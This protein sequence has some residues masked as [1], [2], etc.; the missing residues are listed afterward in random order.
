L[1]PL[2]FSPN[3]IFYNKCKKTNC[4]VETQIEEA[5]QEEDDVNQQNR[6]IQSAHISE[7]AFA[8]AAGSSIP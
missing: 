1:Q 5:K 4:F 8:K 2:L 7:T 3:I 6:K